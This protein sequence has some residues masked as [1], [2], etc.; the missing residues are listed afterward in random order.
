MSFFHSSTRSNYIRLKVLN[1]SNH[2]YWPQLCFVLRICCVCFV[3]LLVVWNWSTL[4]KLK[5]AES[6]HFN[7]LPVNESEFVF[8]GNEDIR[9][10]DYR[11]SHPFENTCHFPTLKTEDPSIDRFVQHSHKV[12][13]PKAEFE[14]LVSQD[15]DGQF[16]IGN[17]FGG[18]FIRP[19]IDCFYRELTGALWPNISEYKFANEWS[20]LPINRPFKMTKDQFAVKCFSKATQNLIYHNAF[21]NIVPRLNSPDVT[22]RYS[23]AI[24]QIDSTSRNQFFRHAPKTLRFMHQNG[25][26]ILNGYTKIGD[27]SAINSMALLAGTSI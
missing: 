23:I 5:V 9:R 10:P 18:V 16:L 7:E 17:P 13:C 11:L 1:V 22:N 6:D 12:I 15:R 8:V 3:F 21:A 24:L 4:L 19:D 27:N 25:F 26:Q 2:L 14:H 20:R